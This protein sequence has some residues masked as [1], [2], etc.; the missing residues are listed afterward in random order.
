[1]YITLGS[2]VNLRAMRN[3][4]VLRP[5]KSINAISSMRKLVSTL[6]NSI[7]ELVNVTIFLLFIFTLFGIFGLQL[8]SGKM[9][10]KCRLTN[11]PLNS[12]YWPKSEIFTR[13]CSQIEGIGY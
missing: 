2:K 12:T 13:S 1:M 7:Q 8:Y 3:L 11:K 4:R 9:A 6:L 5:L 10:N